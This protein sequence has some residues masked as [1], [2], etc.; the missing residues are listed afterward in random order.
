MYISDVV[1]AVLVN[2]GHLEPVCC[3]DFDAGEFL[4]NLNDGGTIDLISEEK[5]WILSGPSGSNI[6]FK[7]LMTEQELGKALNDY[8]ALMALYCIEQ[9]QP[10]AVPERIGNFYYSILF[11]AC[12]KMYRDPSIK[13][14]NYSAA[15]MH[16]IPVSYHATAVKYFNAFKLEIAWAVLD[17]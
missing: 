15:I 8:V 11:H 1:Y 4:T 10:I 3:G 5:G 7:N 16:V 12:W 9:E 14:N 6:E 2:A 17:N 13:R